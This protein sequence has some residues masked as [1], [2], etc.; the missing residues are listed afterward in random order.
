MPIAGAFDALP[1]DRKA[2]L[3][4]D[5]ETEMGPYERGDRLVYSD[6]VHVALGIR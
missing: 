6:A 5:V 4:E 2:A 1:G 3:I